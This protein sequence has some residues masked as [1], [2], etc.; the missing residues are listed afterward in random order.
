MIFWLTVDQECIGAQVYSVMGARNSSLLMI[1]T[2]LI[3]QGALVW[4]L[5][6]DLHSYSIF[7]LLSYMGYSGFRSFKQLSLVS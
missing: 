1:V 4:S 3:A 6:V 2:G 5:T 7:Y